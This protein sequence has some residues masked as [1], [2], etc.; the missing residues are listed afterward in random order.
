MKGELRV[1]PNTVWC[2]K[3][4]KLIMWRIHPKKT[5]YD[6]I[7]ETGWVNIEKKCK[8]CNLKEEIT[9]HGNVY[10][11]YDRTIDPLYSQYEQQ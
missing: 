5:S 10:C 3:L 6:W 4:K 8:E 1:K 11:L 2:P 7:K 9:E